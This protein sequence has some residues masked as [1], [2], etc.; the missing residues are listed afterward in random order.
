MNNVQNI[1]EQFVQKYKNK[2]FE[3]DKTGVKTVDLICA[4]FNADQDHI[5]GQPNKDYIQRELNWYLSQSLN[6]NDIEDTPKIWTSC[7]DPSGFINSNY[8]WCIF[9]KENGNQYQNCLN[10]L[11][12]N[13]SSRRATMIYNRPEMWMDYNKNGRSD[14]MCTY[15]VQFLIRGGQLW[16]YVI[17]RSNDAIFGYNN[18]FAWHKYVLN[19]V[20]DDLEIKDRN[21]M[22]TSG[23]LHIY[24]RHFYLLEHFI[25]TQETSISKKQF[26]LLYGT[27]IV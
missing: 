4:H 22:W 7:A 9:S 19:K 27:T 14:F 26:D 3:I 13:P 5:F 21:L 20:G 15:G 2:E 16:S 23:S 8:G 18:D 25:K 17:M 10:E 12:L 6:V 11:R 24:E 1:R